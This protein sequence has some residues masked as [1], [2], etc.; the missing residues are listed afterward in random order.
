MTVKDLFEFINAN[1]ADMDISVD[2]FDSIAVCA[3][4]KLTDCGK[5]H[6]ERALTLKVEDY[7][8]LGEDEDYE[9]LDGEN[10]RL[11]LAWDLLTSLAGYCSCENFEKWFEE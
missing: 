8:I 4:V 1:H 10:N 6:F 2:G 9:D 7:T 3:P 11:A 5:K